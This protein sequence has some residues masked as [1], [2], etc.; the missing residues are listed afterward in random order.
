MPVEDPLD[1]MHDLSRVLRPEGA[2]DIREEFLRAWA[3][4]NDG[5]DWQKITKTK[6]PEL[7]SDTPNT[8]LFEDLRQLPEKE[9]TDKLV[10]LRTDLENIDVEL[11]LRKVERKN[12]IE[13]SKALRKN[14]ELSKEESKLA[15]SLKPRREKME[16]VKKQRDTVNNNYI[17]LHWIEDEMNKVYKRLTDEVDLMRIPSLD[18][19]KELFSWFFELQSMHQHSKQT[20]ELHNQ[21]IK[22]LDEQKNTLSKLDNVKDQE[23]SDD[24]FGKYSDFDDLAHKLL[25]E[26]IVYT[27]N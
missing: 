6:Y 4:L 8:D 23:R 9:I 1:T 10:R 22:L 26:I 16:Q 19:E 12:A 27:D 13:M 7:V 2:L 11:E 3:I 21:C 14:A 15:N 17:P 5:G 25:L 20:R 18:K 24:S